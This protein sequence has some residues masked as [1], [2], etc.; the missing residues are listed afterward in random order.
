MFKQWLARVLTWIPPHF[1]IRLI[2]EMGRSLDADSVRDAVQ[3]LIADRV[4]VLP[5]DQALRFLFRLDAVLYGIQG[6][7]AVRYDDGV[8]T[9]Y[10]HTRY[11][12]F[13]LGR[14]QPGQRVLDIGCGNGLLAYELARKGACVVG[15]DIAEDKIIAAQKRYV[16]PN[17][18]LRHGD[19]LKKFEAGVFD[20]VVLSNVLEHLGQRVSFLRTVMEHYH[21]HLLLV[22]VPMFERDWRVPLKKELGVEWRLDLTHETEYTLESFT[23][24]I[25]EAGLSIRYLEVR[26][27]ELWVEV[28]GDSFCGWKESRADCETQ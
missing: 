20:V 19:A 21:P 27:G 3:R 17:L 8:H 6:Q 10:R 24:E 4:G 25:R 16:H 9:K 28:V 18:A 26:W 23:R 1:R 15:M 11:N 12:D 13:F 2:Q 5:A 22:R 14:I 7:Q